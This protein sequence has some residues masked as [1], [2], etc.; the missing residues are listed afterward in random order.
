MSP[1][2]FPPCPSSQ[3]HPDRTAP[4]LHPRPCLRPAEEQMPEA[5]WHGAALETEQHVQAVTLAEAP[6]RARARVVDIDLA[7][8]VAAMPGQV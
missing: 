8:H 2:F 7:P 6:P 3:G 1:V 5:C 4:P